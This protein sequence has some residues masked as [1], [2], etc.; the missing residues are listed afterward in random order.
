MKEDRDFSLLKFL[1][2]YLRAQKCH[3]SDLYLQKIGRKFPSKESLTI[4]GFMNRS[5]FSFLFSRV[6]P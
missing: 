4:I 2:R 3:A 6:K 5:L 1:P